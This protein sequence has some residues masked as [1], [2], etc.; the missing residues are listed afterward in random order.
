MASLTQVEDP[1]MLC[2]N[3]TTKCLRVTNGRQN[4]MRDHWSMLW[5]KPIPWR[6]HGLGTYSLMHANPI[7]LGVVC[8]PFA[9]MLHS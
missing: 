4:S 5:A 8:K 3:R 7:H 2:T 6:V 1:I 9:L